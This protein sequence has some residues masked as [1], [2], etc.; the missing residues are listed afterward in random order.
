MLGQRQAQ[1]RHGG[2]IR[3]GG[4]RRGGNLRLVVARARTCIVVRRHPATAA[5]PRHRPP[6]LTAFLC[7]RRRFVSRT[8]A[9]RGTVRWSLR[10]FIHGYR[11]PPPAAG[12]G[13]V[14]A[15]FSASVRTPAGAPPMNITYGIALLVAIALA[16][17]LIVALLKP[18]WFE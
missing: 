7:E 1:C 6:A 16:V 15:W 14:H 13:R 17:Y 18:E 5:A 11:L 2:P 9:L 8:Y 10:E 3:D 12:A 4:V